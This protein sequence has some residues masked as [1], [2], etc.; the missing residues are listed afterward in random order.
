ML[1]TR[2]VAPSHPAVAQSPRHVQRCLVVL[3][4]QQQDLEFCLWTLVD[5]KTPARKL[6]ALQR[7]G[8]SS[9]RRSRPHPD[10]DVSG[11]DRLFLLRES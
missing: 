4:V 8:S 10:N 6:E 9:S 5:Y 11:E 3:T 7:F 1:K 2:A